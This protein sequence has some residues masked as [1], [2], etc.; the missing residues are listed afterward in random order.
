MP[1]DPGLED[2]STR[3]RDEVNGNQILVTNADIEIN[4][5]RANPHQALIFTSIWE[6][7]EDTM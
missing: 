3:S 6:I 2:C 7:S 4:G 1:V 5:R